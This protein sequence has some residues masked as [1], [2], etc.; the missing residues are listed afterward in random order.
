MIIEFKDW[1]KEKLYNL[2]GYAEPRLIVTHPLRTFLFSMFV[3]PLLLGLF[4]IGVLGTVGLLLSPIVLLFQNTDFKFS[5]PAVFFRLIAIWVFGFA[6]GVTSFYLSAAGLL[7]YCSEL[8]YS[9]ILL[10][11]GKLATG[12]IIK[13]WETSTRSGNSTTISK[14]CTIQY[15]I[16]QTSKTYSESGSSQISFMQSLLEIELTLDRNVTIV[17]NPKNPI[18]ARL[19]HK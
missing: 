12:K 13:I 4:I 9:T 6:I 5:E 10:F 18:M 15:T 11:K 2:K 17:Y 19:I 8:F 1:I 7:I 16:P 14:H 3:G